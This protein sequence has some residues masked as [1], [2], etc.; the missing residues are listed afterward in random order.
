MVVPVVLMLIVKSGFPHNVDI[1]SYS[2]SPGIIISNHFEIVPETKHEHTQGWKLTEITHCRASDLE[3][4]LA[5]L[6]STS[7]SPDFFLT[8]ICVAPTTVSIK[9]HPF[10]LNVNFNETICFRT[11]YNVISKV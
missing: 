9:T 1:N 5:L 2:D 8:P 10:K 6:N 3:N 7:T 11:S 4:L